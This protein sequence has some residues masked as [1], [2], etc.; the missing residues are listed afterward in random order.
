MRALTRKLLR[1]LLSL[2]AQLGAIA[3][4]MACGVGALVMMVAT[5]RALVSGL[6]K[7]YEQHRFADVFAHLKRAPMSLASRLREIPGVALV[8]PRVAVDVTL[9]APG[10]G[11]PVVGRMISLPASGDPALN[12]LHLRKGRAPEPGRSGEVIASEAFCEALELGPGDSIP[13]VINGKFEKLKI[14]GTALSPEFVYAIR[15]GSFVPDDRRFGV[16]WMLEEQLGP[17]YGMDGAFN[18]VLI[19]VGRGASPDAVIAAVDAITKPYGGTGAFPRKEQTSHQYISDE[20]SQL[21][22]MGKVTP[23]IFLA[24]SA[25]LL[26]IVLARLVRTQR[27]QIGVLKAFGY[28]RRDI[29]LHYVGMVAAVAV[30]GGTLGVAAG[31]LMGSWMTSMYSRFFRLPDAEFSIDAWTPMLGIGV[32][33]AAAVAGAL[34]SALAAGRIPPA[35]AMRPA[36]PTDYR[37]T[38]IE[39][40]GLIAWLS[41]ATRMIVRHLERHPFR[42]L[43]SSIGVAMA[44]G[45]LTLGSFVSDAVD[46]LMDFQFSAAQRY[47]VS[48]VFVEPRD[49]RA[50]RELA[51]LDGVLECEPFRSVPVKLHHGPRERRDALT[52][53]PAGQALG[54]A[55]DDKGRPVAVPPSGLVLSDTLADLLGAQIGSVVTVEVLEGQRPT[56]E[57]P[58]EG[59]CAT[60]IGTAAYI[61]IDALRRVMRE[62]DVAS[63]VYM[64]VDSARS[65]EI[66]ARLKETP[67][68]AASVVKQAAVD[69]F[70]K[71]LAQNLLTIRSFNM[72]FACVIAVG[73]VYNSARIALGERARELATLRVLGLYRSEVAGIFLGELSLLVLLAIPMGATLGYWFCTLAAA[74]LAT[75]THRVPMVV[76]PSTIAFSVAVVLIASAVTGWQTRRQLD[77]LDLLSVLKATG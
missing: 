11:E 54:R 13:A 25:L 60:F 32:S 76:S 15:P 31:Y 41:P 30:I 17:M 23:T 27:E 40:V 22:N 9:D 74:A 49:G 57:L 36:A 70:S 35:E 50:V 67:G 29:V 8:E 59:I 55:L 71:T 33:T 24:V 34:Q 18:D 45:V 58:V 68:V 46:F 75:E 66:Y 64:T 47:D 39:R 56:V 77:R 4:V 6:E 69:S 37:E 10:V 2:K 42:A 3:L 72:L 21:H 1:D 61:D 14:V 52:G 26:N 19:R 48:A 16:F 65:G 28:R 38:V 5:S 53:L 62:S 44:I 73:V 7:Y 51:A 12:A 43:V 63:G 20:M